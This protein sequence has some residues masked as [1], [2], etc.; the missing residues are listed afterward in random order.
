MTVWTLPF[1][2]I[3][4]HVVLRVLMA[5][6]AVL[7]WS[8]FKIPCKANIESANSIVSGQN[9]QPEVARAG[10]H[11]CAYMCDWLPGKSPPK[12]R[13]PKHAIAANLHGGQAASPAKPRGPKPPQFCAPGCRKAF[14]RRAHAWPVP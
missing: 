14:N 2:I 7:K 5:F 8:G 12:A 13:N 1:K 11:L 4:M 10:N 9:R 6:C 3:V